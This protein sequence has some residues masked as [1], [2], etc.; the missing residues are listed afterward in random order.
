[1]NGVLI[2]RGDLGRTKLLLA[3]LLVIA[4]VAL[5]AYGGQYTLTTFIRI[6]YFGFLAISVGLLLGQGGMISLTQ[7]AFFGIG[8][9]VMFSKLLEVNLPGGIL[10][11]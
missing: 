3:A 2:G 10:P 5:P 1:M 4:L 11:F 9:Y 6:V 8:G 7:T